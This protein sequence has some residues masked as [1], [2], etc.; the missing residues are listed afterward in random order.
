MT[1]TITNTDS[2]IDSRDVIARIKELKEIL[3]SEWEHLIGETYESRTF[4]EWLAAA[5]GD[6]DSEWQD[7]AKELAAL[8]ALQEE[9]A[10]IAS[11]WKYGEVLIHEDYFQDYCQEM[12]EDIGDLPKG[13]PSYIVVDWEA[14]CRNLEQDYSH[15]D[16][17][18]VTYLIKS[19]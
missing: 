5:Q 17:D 6:C 14:T 4:N 2:I 18:G 8:E 9:A 3:Q 7:D 10:S 19:Y 1:K 15:V 11:D 12:V 16:F 13:L